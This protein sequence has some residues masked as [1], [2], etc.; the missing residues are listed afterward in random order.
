MPDIRRLRWPPGTASAL[1]HGPDDRLPVLDN[2]SPPWSWICK[3]HITSRRGDFYTATGWAAGPRL[4]MTAGHCVYIQADEE[5]AQTI[6]MTFGLTG[7]TY[8]QK[9]SASR[10]VT[11][12]GWTSTASE[13]FDVGGI[14][15]DQDLPTDLGFFAV[16][17]PTDDEL[18]N[19]T[20]NC[21]GYAADIEG[22]AGLVTQGGRISSMTADR[23]VYNLDTYNGQSGSPL[24]AEVSG[25][26]VAVGIHTWGDQANNSGVRV[27][28]DVLTAI[29][30]WKSS[31]Q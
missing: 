24:W 8:R 4:V 30:Q 25:Q 11:L 21:S 1:V 3:L 6:D 19:L 12:D 10:F 26:L 29:R 15:L 2:Q 7:T 31:V 13:D 16:G 5:W 20:I 23:L 28:P 18:S 14:L 27:T 22:G 9:V 17:D